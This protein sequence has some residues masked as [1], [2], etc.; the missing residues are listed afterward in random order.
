MNQFMAF[1][2]SLIPKTDTNSKSAH[3]LDVKLSYLKTYLSVSF[4]NV[5]NR[6]VATCAFLRKVGAGRV[7]TIQPFVINII[8]DC[9]DNWDVV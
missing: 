1:L 2:S 9:G 4:I 5:Q 7:I 6:I 3:T 8:D